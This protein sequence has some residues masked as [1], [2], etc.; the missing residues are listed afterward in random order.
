M[1]HSV[2]TLGY[3][4]RKMIDNL[5]ATISAPYLAFSTLAPSLALEPTGFPS[6]APRGWLPLYTMV[7]FRPDISYAAA[8]KKAD[9]QSTIIT[10]GSVSLGVGVIGLAVMRF[11]VGSGSSRVI[12]WY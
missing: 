7:T 10:I 6:S 11:M 4:F 3:I 9:R 8:K 12:K 1:R 5:F 2:T